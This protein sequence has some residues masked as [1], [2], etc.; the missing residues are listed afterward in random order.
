M[1]ITYGLWLLACCWTDSLCHAVWKQ[2]EHRRHFACPYQILRINRKLIFIEAEGVFQFSANKHPRTAQ[3]DTATKLQQ[4]QHDS[5]HHID[6]VPRL[7]AK[8]PSASASCGDGFC[9]WCAAQKP[10]EVGGNLP[11]SNRQPCFL[12]IFQCSFCQC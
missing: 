4:K 12:G 10:R 8:P 6:S 7:A 5:N 3:E 1:F 11:S 2:T 9:C